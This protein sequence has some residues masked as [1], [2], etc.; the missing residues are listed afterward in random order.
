MAETTTNKISIKFKLSDGASLP[1]YKTTGAAGADICSNED[2]SINPG[3]WKMVSTGLFPE[4]P[5]NFE[6]QVRSRSGLAAKNGVFV[7]NSPG[8]VDSD[9]RGEI[10]VILANMSD[11]VFEIKKGDRIAQLVVSPVQ[12]ADFS[13]VLEVSETQRSTGGFGST[14]IR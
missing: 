6:I 3:S 14:G 4:I 11:K 13:I 1:E 10:K 2:C 9:Y 12:Q 7:L 8:T 5:E